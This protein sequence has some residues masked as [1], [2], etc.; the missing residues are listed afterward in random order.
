MTRGAIDESILLLLMCQTPKNEDLSSHYWPTRVTP[1]NNS[2]HHICIK[3]VEYSSMITDHMPKIKKK[4]KK[5]KR[6][7]KI[8]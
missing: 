3:R 2:L 4:K 1:Q 8:N 6:R 5:K 7:E